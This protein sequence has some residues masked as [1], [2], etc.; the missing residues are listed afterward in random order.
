[1]FGI[2]DFKNRKSLTR[3]FQILFLQSLLPAIVELA[4]DTKWRVRLAIIEYMPALAGQ[5]GQEFF[6]QKLR[7]L[8]M[9]WLNDH[10]Y[11][12]REAATLNM[13]KL[14][15]KFGSAW[16]EQAII[17]MILV[18]ARNKNYLHS[19]SINFSIF[20]RIHFSHSNFTHCRNDLSVLH[21]RF[22]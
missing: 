3:K 4:E 13:K 7:G 5:L 22:G 14:V 1:M 21:Q 18:M 19:K 12:I 6:D 9:G 17:P 16:A 2:K 8:C 10:V 15:E 20:L 11:A